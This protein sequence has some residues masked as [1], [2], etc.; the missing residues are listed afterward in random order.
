[1]NLSF[2]A[3]ER[4]FEREI[5]IDDIKNAL[6]YGEELETEDNRKIYWINFNALSN[7]KRYLNEDIIKYF[8]IYIVL[9]KNNEV[10]LSAYYKLE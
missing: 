8:G 6:I 9:D 1:M 2:H 10:L 3:N 5:K 4:L 7:A